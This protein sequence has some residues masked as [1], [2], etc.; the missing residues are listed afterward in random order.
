MEKSFTRYTLINIIKS[1]KKSLRI[2]S[3]ESGV[4]QHTIEN[5][6]YTNKVPSIDNTIA[7]LNALGYK[8]TATKEGL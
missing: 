7:V 1:S 6:L 5:W 3:Q 2:I 8:L 4:P